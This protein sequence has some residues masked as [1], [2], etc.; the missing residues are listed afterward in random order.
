MNDPVQ[1]YV[2]SLDLAAT[3]SVRQTI[4]IVDESEKTQHVSLIKLLNY[5]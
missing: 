5:H 1:V 4:L 2:G 3:H